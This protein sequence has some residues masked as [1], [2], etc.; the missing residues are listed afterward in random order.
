MRD[1]SS[2][3]SIRKFLVVLIFLVYWLLIFEG[4]LR[5]WCF[6]EYH[7]VLFFIRDPVVLSIYLLVAIYRI[8]PK[9]SLVFLYGSVVTLSLGVLVAVQYWRLHD[10]PLIVLLYGWRN[11]AFYFFLVWIMGRV[12]RWDDIQSFIRTNLLV[13]IPMSVLTM[14]Q[15]YSPPS[16]WIN[17]SVGDIVYTDAGKHGGS[18]V[19]TIGT[20]TFFHGYQLYLGSL[21]IF[22]SINWIMPKSQRA[23]SGIGLCLATIAVLI[24]LSLDFT[25]VPVYITIFTLMASLASS[26]IIRRN[27]I[28]MRAA[29]LPLGLFVAVIAI[30][31]IFFP[32]AA[33]LRW[34]R[35]FYLDNTF[36]RTIGVFLKFAELLNLADHAPI[37]Y[38]I[39]TT[40]RGAASFGV[41]AFRLAGEDEW[42]RILS[43]VGPFMGPLYIFLRLWLVLW[44]FKNAILAVRTS[45]NPFPLLAIIYI[46]PIIAVWYLTTIGSV[47]GYGWWFAGFCLAVNRQ[48]GQSRVAIQY[49]PILN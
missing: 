20:F 46:G 44:L 31:I 3:E 19:R 1:F 29:I 48:L 12:L 25:R 37:G 11:Y 5:K 35:M 39:G 23:L 41:E 49:N 47:N 40:S 21:I 32:E 2:S 45:N 6:P 38:G 34:Q 10:I 22:V 43:E 7:R 24:M 27:N 16:A 8:W 9:V 15:Y 26:L 36:E 14:I 42:R 28:R 33:Y 13:A 4:A 17:A 18:I 30:S